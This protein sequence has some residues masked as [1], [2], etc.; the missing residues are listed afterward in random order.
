M[1]MEALTPST[2]SPCRLKILCKI[3][4]GKIG[5]SLEIKAPEINNKTYLTRTPLLLL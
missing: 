2:C 3:K 1:F 5:V 4:R